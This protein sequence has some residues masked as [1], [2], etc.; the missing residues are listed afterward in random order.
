MGAR[1]R[2]EERIAGRM[3]ELS[4]IGDTLFLRKKKIRILY[5]KYILRIIG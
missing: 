5:W 3:A 1:K 4:S 2:T